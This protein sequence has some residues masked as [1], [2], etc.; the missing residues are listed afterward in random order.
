MPSCRFAAE[1]DNTTR[2]RFEGRLHVRCTDRTICERGYEHQADQE[3]LAREGF[4]VP[5]S[6]WLNG[7]FFGEPYASTYFGCRG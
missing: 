7:F 3:R 1:L 4:F 5:Q 6:A 2:Q